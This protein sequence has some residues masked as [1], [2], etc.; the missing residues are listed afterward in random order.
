MMDRL[1]IVNNYIRT[2]NGNNLIRNIIKH[3]NAVFYIIKESGGKIINAYHVQIA[4][5]YVF[6]A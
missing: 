1:Q 4:Q 2:E 6:I 3:W 5:P